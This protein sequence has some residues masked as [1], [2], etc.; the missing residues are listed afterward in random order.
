MFRLGMLRMILYVDLAVS[1]ISYDL[2]LYVDLHYLILDDPVNWGRHWHY[3]GFQAGCF[4]SV[5]LREAFHV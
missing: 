4:K 2:D 1:N 3:L 5:I